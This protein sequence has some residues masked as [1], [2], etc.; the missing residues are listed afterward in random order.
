MAFS[1][2]KK[3]SFAFTTLAIIDAILPVAARLRSY[4]CS[5]LIAVAL[6]TLSSIPPLFGQDPLSLLAGFVWGFKTGFIVVVVSIFAGE[7]FAFL[8]YRHCLEQKANEFRLKHQ[9]HYGT[10]VRVIE[11]GSYPLIWL[12]RLSFLPTHLTT[13][14]F[15]TMPR[16]SYVGWTL[17]YWLS[18]FK[19]LVPVYAGICLAREKTTTANTV[20]IILCI[21]I[22]AGTALYIWF[23]YKRLEAS[24]AEEELPLPTA[25]EPAPL[26]SLFDPSNASSTSLLNESPFVTYDMPTPTPSRQDVFRTSRYLQTPSVD[27]TELSISDEDPSS[28]DLLLNRN[29]LPGGQKTLKSPASVTLRPR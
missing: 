25:L 1:R 26:T 7:S 16:V 20:G 6:I 29:T 10:F 4:K 28:E 22:T 12:I 27:P 3:I 23:R 11:E 13:V 17:A 19:Y 5:W 9:K 15:A 18:S 21:V 14:F 24:S 2:R 8:M